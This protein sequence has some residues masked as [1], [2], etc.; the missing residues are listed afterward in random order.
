MTSIAQTIIDKYTSPQAPPVPSVVN[1]EKP[2]T[3]TRP[4]PTDAILKNKE[5][6]QS[7]LRVGIWTVEYKKV[8][9]SN[10]IMECTLD[11]RH[12][13]EPKDPSHVQVLRVRPADVLQVYATD[14]HG[15]RSFVVQN[16]S[17]IY[18]ALESL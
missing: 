6:L 5:A 3:S 12:L 14:R 7:A 8:D 13:P 15:W 17:K 2:I 16:V 11:P 9:G 10:G 4:A 18:K 1:A